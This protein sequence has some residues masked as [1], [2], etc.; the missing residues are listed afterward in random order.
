[1]WALARGRAASTSALAA[2]RGRGRLRERAAREDEHRA[3]MGVDRIEAVSAGVGRAGRAAPAPA[4]SP[5]AGAARGQLV[6]Q[7]LPVSPKPSACF[8][9]SVRSYS[10]PAT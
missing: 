10:R 3:E 6:A 1:M 7:T 2:S 8:V 5:V 4:L 9:A